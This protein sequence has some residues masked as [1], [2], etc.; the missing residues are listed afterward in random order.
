MSD[1]YG[2]LGYLS[3]QKGDIP[4]AISYNY[5]Y[6]KISQDLKD[7][8]GIATALNNLGEIYYKQGAADKALEYYERSL[9]LLEQMN[10]QKQIGVLL[11]T[12][13]YILCKKGLYDKGIEYCNK[14]LAINEK[15]GFKQGVAMSLNNL[16]FAYRN[17]GKP[18]LALPF[19]ERGIKIQEE[20]NDKDALGYS[21]NNLSNIYFS[22]KR[23]EKALQIGNRSLL[24]AHEIGSTE[25]IRN[26]EQLLYSIYKAKGEFKDAIEHYERYIVFRDSVLNDETKKAALE[27]QVQYEF[28]LKASKLRADQDKKDAVAKEEMQRQKVIRNSFIVGFGLVLALA[29][30]IL[31]GYWQKKKANETISKQKIEVEKQKELVEAHQKDIID[32]ITYAKRLQEAILPPKE[33]VRKHLPQSFILY[34]PKDIVAGDF[35]WMEAFEDTTYI[36]ACDCTGHGVPGAMVSVVCSNALNRAVKEFGLRDTGK[37]LDKVTDLVVETFEK[38]DTEVKD[39][40][41]I[42]LLAINKASGRVSWSGANNPLW[43]VQNGLLQD[44]SGDKQ[45]IGRYDNR[46]PF[47]THL[48]P[49]TAPA[50]FFLFTDGYADQFGGEKGKKFKYKQLED[51][52]LES[53][54]S[55]IEEQRSILEGKFDRWKGSLEQVDDVL[56]IGIRI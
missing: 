13:G 10:N 28:D 8:L 46:K 39:G 3:K 54:G 36:A 30:F 19:F 37:I 7:S 9:K 11:N 52:L 51:V 21:L 55:P 43:Y 6:L 45:P 33:L 23:Y 35:Y 14:G 32:S 1:S 16:G 44:I 17:S 40:M 53:S 24:L 27:K 31:R 15:I 18:E 25:G 42:S 5:D 38:S 26:A 2:W 20:I 48:I 56:V 4:K 49:A 12:I 22:E 29:F 34:K 41:D 50:S 47:R